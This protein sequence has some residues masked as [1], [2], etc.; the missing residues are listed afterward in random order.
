VTGGWGT[1]TYHAVEVTIGLGETWEGNGPRPSASPLP[2]FAYV[3]NHPLGEGWFHDRIR[4]GQIVVL[5]SDPEEAAAVVQARLD[6]R[7]T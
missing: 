4:S 7:E 6:A 2:I 5:P 3:E 1:S